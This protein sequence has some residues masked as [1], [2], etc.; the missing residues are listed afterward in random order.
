MKSRHCS[1]LACQF[2]LACVALSALS[3]CGAEPITS[4]DS[5]RLAKV[6]REWE[7]LRDAA[8]KLPEKEGVRKYGSKYERLGEMLHDI[9]QKQLSHEEMRQLAASCGSLP[10]REKDRSDFV[11]AVLSGMAYK[12]VTSG[13][14]DTLVKFLSIRCLVRAAPNCDI[15]YFVLV[16]GDKLK[17]P[18]T[19][20]GEAFSKCKTL[21]VRRQLADSVRRAF[22]GHEIRGKDDADFVTKAM[23]WYEQNKD[24]LRFNDMYGLYAMN[25]AEEIYERHPRSNSEF[26]R[27]P[28]QEPLFM[29]SKAK[30]EKDGT[31]PSK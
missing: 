28:K 30:G 12:F 3:G 19:V 17:D 5:P 13:D 10:I 22:R 18:I 14:R 29:F 27:G 8:K 20:L 24:H 6:Q 25:T 31:G 1:R 15:E 11:N 21:E 23:Q 7:S 16:Y 4:W 2:V 26:P 9:V